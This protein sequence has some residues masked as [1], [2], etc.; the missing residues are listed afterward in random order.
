MVDAHQMPW[1]AS[2]TATTT[3]HMQSHVVGSDASHGPVVGR[4]HGT[5]NLPLVSLSLPRRYITMGGYLPYG[6][7]NMGQTRSTLI[8][9]IESFIR[10]QGLSER[11]FGEQAVGDKKVLYRL[12]HGYG[13]NL[14]T[15]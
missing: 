12:R 2:C 11:R 3:W 14:C 9:T 7:A 8:S 6:V 13:V 4:T 1:R 10:E 15:I 5:P